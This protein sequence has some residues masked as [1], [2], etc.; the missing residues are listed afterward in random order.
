MQREAMAEPINRVD[1]F[2]AMVLPRCWKG[3][4]LSIDEIMEL[5]HL[6]PSTIRWCIRQLKTGAEGNFIIRKR[7]RD[8]D[9]RGQWE[10]YIKRKPAQLRLPYEEKIA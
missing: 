1:F 7:K 3:Q 4:W 8:P 9:Y 10:F 2:L 6:H 5:T